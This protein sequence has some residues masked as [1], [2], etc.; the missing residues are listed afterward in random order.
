MP[1]LELVAT[2]PTARAGFRRL[3]AGR[4]VPRLYCSDTDRDRDFDGAV[5]D[6]RVV[7]EAWDAW[8][9][10]VDF[11]TQ[12]VADASTLDITADDPLNQ[13]GSDGGSLSLRERID[14]RIGDSAH[15]QAAAPQ[16][17]TGRGMIRCRT[18]CANDHALLGKDPVLGGSARGPGRRFGPFESGCASR[19]SDTFSPGADASG[20]ADRQRCVRPWVGE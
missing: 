16:G 6:P 4:D 15:R 7:A 8:H 13:H 11:A 1:L 2:W 10:E 9:A 12:F 19:G 5:P 20:S 17:A 3:M 18:V 14:G